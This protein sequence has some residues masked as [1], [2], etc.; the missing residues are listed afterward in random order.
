MDRWPITELPLLLKVDY[1]PQ[2]PV[3]RLRNHFGDND[4]LIPGMT[5]KADFWAYEPNDALL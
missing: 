2:R 1:S 4:D 5:R 3:I